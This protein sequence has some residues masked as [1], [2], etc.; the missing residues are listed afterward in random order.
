[1]TVKTKDIR[2]YEMVRRRWEAQHP[3][4]PG[5]LGTGGSPADAIKSLR[6]S[7]HKQQGERL[8]ATYQ[9]RFTFGMG[10]GS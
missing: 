6:R 2:C 8:Q 9:H 10:E 4:F 3:K 5:V 7:I 1:M